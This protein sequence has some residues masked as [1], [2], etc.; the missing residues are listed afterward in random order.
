MIKHDVVDYDPYDGYDRPAQ[1]EV[2]PYVFVL[3]TPLAAY[4]LDFADH[5]VSCIVSRSISAL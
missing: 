3:F 2:K 1:R 4:T 5:N